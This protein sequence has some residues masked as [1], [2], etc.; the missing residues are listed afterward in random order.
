M[1]IEQVE[2]AL[3]AEVQKLRKLPYSYWRVAV[4]DTYNKT[5]T[6]PHS[7]GGVYHLSVSAMLD[8]TTRDTVHVT[9]VMTRSWS[10]SVHRRQWWTSRPKALTEQRRWS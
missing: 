5:I 7:R 4:G 6:D 2:A 9:L 1:E 10:M 3:D 8:D